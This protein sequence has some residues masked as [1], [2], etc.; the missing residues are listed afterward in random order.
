MWHVRRE[1]ACRVLV[2][3]PEGNNFTDLGEEG[4]IILKWTLMKKG[5]R[6][7]TGFTSLG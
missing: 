5:C 2:W 3:K 1:N 7:S 6:T 4:K